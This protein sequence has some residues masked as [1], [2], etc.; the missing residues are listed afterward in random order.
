MHSFWLLLFVIKL[1]SQINIFNLWKL[2]KFFVTLSKILFKL[3]RKMIWTVWTPLRANYTNFHK[4]LPH[5]LFIVF[6][7]KN[8]CPDSTCIYKNNSDFV[9][10]HHLT[11]LIANDVSFYKFSVVL[12]F[13]NWLYSSER[14]PE[15]A[16]N[17]QYFK[18]LNFLCQALKTLA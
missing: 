18:T 6:C 1:Y 14:K 15:N 2:W 7:G 16:G 8:L 3:D 17:F 4:L 11:H 13:L 9:Q 5:V 12:V 10:R